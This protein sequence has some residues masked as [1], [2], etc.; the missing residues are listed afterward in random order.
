[1]E[2]QKPDGGTALDDLVFRFLEECEVSGEP[3]SRILDAICRDYP[4]EADELRA[5]VEVLAGTGLSVPDESTSGGATRIVGGYRLLDRLGAGGMGVVH[6]ARPLEGGPDVALKLLHPQM[7]SEPEARERF[8]REATAIECLDH[9]SIV[10][11]L[12]HGEVLDEE[13]STPYLAMALHLGIPL[14]RAIARIRREPIRTE[15]GSDIGARIHSAITSEID[16]IARSSRFRGP[17]WKIVARFGVDLASAIAHAHE[18]G[19]VHRDV[20]PSN[21]LV[22]HDGRVLLLDFGLAITRD[23]GRLTRSGAQLG[24]LP[25]MAPEQIAGRT[26]E[27]VVDVYSLGL[28]LYELLTLTPAFEL[29]TPDSLAAAIERGASFRPSKAATW[30]PE[31]VRVRL[32]AIIECATQPDPAHRYGSAV[33]LGG[34]LS[35]LLEG[36]PLSIQP[37]GRI[38]RARRAARR[39]P[40]QV[41]T[42]LIVALF[43]GLGGI[44]FTTYERRLA[45]E[46]R[47]E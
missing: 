21:V 37:I 8:A 40:W 5:A 14:D 39:Y 13:I 27:G 9:P 4:G 45:E 28:V 32:D 38:E 41:A 24:S 44:V 43:L 1:M 36:R 7:K 47:R 10:R 19:V 35:A 25:Y 30:I 42:A 31:D 46:E 12:D 18:R 34:D 15:D 6:R 29:S 3:P 22:T 26:V 11:V 23:S 33:A 16:P 2:Q 17:W 20:K